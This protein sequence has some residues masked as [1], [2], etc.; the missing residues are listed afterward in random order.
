MNKYDDDD[1]EGCGR[2]SS[3]EGSF[4]NGIS[5]VNRTEGEGGGLTRT[6]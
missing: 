3:Q 6:L 4:S 2:S 5:T 1:E